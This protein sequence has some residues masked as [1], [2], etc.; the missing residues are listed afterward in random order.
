MNPPVRN[1]AIYTRKS[2]EEGLD[3]DFNSLDAQRESCQAYI[4]SQKAEGWVAIKENYDDGGFSGGNVQRPALQKLL[5]DIKADKIH[6]IVV[7]KIDRLT[8]SL[9]DFAKLV[10]VFDQHQV[11]FVS[12]TQSFNTTNSMG[13]LT[14]N[15]LLSFAQ[16]EREVTGER[17]RDKIA[18]S[19]KKGMWMGGTPPMGYDLDNHQLLVNEENA[20]IV[21][22]IFE[23]YLV[24]GCVSSLQKELKRGGY[25]SALRLS[26]KGNSSG[27]C[28]FSRGILYKILKNTAYIGRIKHKDVSYDGQHESIIL[29]DIWDAVQFKLSQNASVA[30]GDKKTAE[31][32]SLKGILFD[33]E[34]TPYS[35]SYTNKGKKRYR[36]YI[37]QNL[38]QYKDH[39]KGVLSRIPAHAI[40]SAV[41]NAIKQNLKN[42]NGIA[43]LLGL[44][45]REDCDAIDYIQRHYESFSDNELI[46]VIGKI[47]LDTDILMIDINLHLMR[48]LIARRLVL[49]MPPNEDKETACIKASYHARKSYLGSV[50]VEPKSDNNILNNLHPKAQKTLVRGIIWR[51]QHFQGMTL[52]E[53]ASREGLSA[54]YVAN[55]IYQSFITL[56]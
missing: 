24:L 7:Y 40:E 44:D 21:R 54:T 14:L 53:I 2:S 13:R 47:R 20:K 38:L 49:K 45:I 18:A 12:V 1:C 10:E 16:F 31:L 19:K 36:Y 41:V 42:E 28:D 33:S 4:A 43:E 39:P 17:I 35:P 32:N 26:L 37:S 8:R 34:G 22:H 11:T 46:S 56:S 29:Q 30:R 50:I 15:V 25:K 9:M 27:G 23:R 55:T 52:N 3:Q 5:A 6:I 51:D 48:E